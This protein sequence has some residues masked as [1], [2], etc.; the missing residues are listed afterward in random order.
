MMGK[1]IER[2]EEKIVILF[3][4]ESAR[5]Q[6]A[7]SRIFDLLAH[8]RMSDVGMTFSNIVERLGG[9]V[10]DEEMLHHALSVLYVCNDVEP[11]TQEDRARLMGYPSKQS[12]PTWRIPGAAVLHRR[13]AEMNQNYRFVPRE[14]SAQ[15]E[16]KGRVWTAHVNFEKAVDVMRLV[17]R[18][19]QQEASSSSAAT[20]WLPADTPHMVP[21]YPILIT[22]DGI[23][24]RPTYMQ[25][26]RLPICQAGWVGSPLHGVAVVH[27]CSSVPPNVLNQISA[28]INFESRRVGA[29]NLRR[30]R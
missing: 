13:V 23:T 28:Q 27:E 14:L 30:G 15:V 6:E 3:D 16:D 25:L 11:L 17:P 1:V 4:E 10:F 29:R 20:M 19:P 8:P 26:R 9:G 12:L 24:I 2:T 5:A 18:D 22:R 7:M 21:V